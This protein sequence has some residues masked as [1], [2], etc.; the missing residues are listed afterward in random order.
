MAKRKRLTKKQKKINKRERHQKSKV[1]LKKQIRLNLKR[2]DTAWS[3]EIRKDNCLVCSTS[4]KLNA[5]HIIIREYS[6]LRYNLK[7]GVS[8]CVKHHKYCKKIS[9]HNNPFI[10]FLFFRKHRKE[11]FEY[12][13]DFLKSRSIV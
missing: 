6:P 7:N 11:Q 5:H 4:E 2:K 13:E 10:F 1:Y 8:L 9:A 12:L 3:I